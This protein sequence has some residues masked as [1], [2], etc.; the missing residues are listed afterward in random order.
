MLDRM[1]QG[2][3]ERGDIYLRLGETYRRRGDSGAAIQALEKAREL[4]PNIR[5][6]L[7]PLIAALEAAGRSSEAFQIRESARMIESNQAVT[8]A[9]FLREELAFEEKKLE[10]LQSRPERAP[11]AITAVQLRLEEM[12]R[13]LQLAVEVMLLR[14]QE[15]PQVAGRVL[16]VIDSAGME[17]SK[18]SLLHLP[19]HLGDTL[20]DAAVEASIAAVKAFD[21]NLEVSMNLLENGQVRIE[22]GRPRR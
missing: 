2:S 16:A 15:Q 3:E 12:R 6:V 10:A 22:I 8:T 20:T 7:I 14:Q 19:V 17:T 1:N 9:N 11:E 4:S 21:A 5:E 13:R 18:A